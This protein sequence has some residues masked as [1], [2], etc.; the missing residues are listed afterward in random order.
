MRN[1]SSLFTGI[2]LLAFGGLFLLAET[3]GVLL[4]PLGIRAGW[5]Q[6]WPLAVIL[7]G[8]AFWLAILVWWDRRWRIS[9]LVIPG[10]IIVANGLLLFYQNLTRHWASWAYLWPLEPISVAVG[11]LML[12]ALGPRSRGLLVASA[13]V[14]GIGAVFFVVFSS[15]WG[16]WLVQVAGAGALILAGVLLL[17]RGARGQVETGFPQE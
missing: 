11:L 17:M 10:T 3:T 9:G 2:V 8:L 14:G 13:I 6:L 16:G 7:T 1:R 15:I 4:S 5:A 12:Y